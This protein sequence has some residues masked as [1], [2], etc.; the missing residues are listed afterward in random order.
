MTLA[1]L[2]TGVASGIVT[3]SSVIHSLTLASL[4]WTLPATADR[5]SRS[6]RIPTRRPKSMTRA[7]PTP[8]PA[9]CRF[10]ERVLG[11]DCEEIARHYIPKQAWHPKRA[12]IQTYLTIGDI[13]PFSE[14][15]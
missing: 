15:H 1:A 8:L 11:S 4:V 10:A 14:L 5:R 3:G 6:V 13:V 9:L 12:I 7:A 2:P